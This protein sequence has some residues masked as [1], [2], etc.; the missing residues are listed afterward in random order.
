VHNELIPF[1]REPQVSFDRLTFH[2]SDIHALLKELIIAPAFFLGLVH[3]QICIS[4]QQFSASAVLRV[5]AYSYASRYSKTVVL[6][7]ERRAQ[8][9]QYFP[10]FNARIARCASPPRRHT[11]SEVRTAASKRFAIN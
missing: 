11:V 9:T 6:H 4:D 1:Q 8:R 7:L 10:G 5:S 3:G 2:S